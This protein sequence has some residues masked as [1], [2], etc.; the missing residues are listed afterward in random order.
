MVRAWDADDWTIGQAAQSSQMH[1]PAHDAVPGSRSVRDRAST[2]PS[3]F[4][5]HNKPRSSNFSKLPDRVCRQMSWRVCGSVSCGLGASRAA[6]GAKPCGSGR[7]SGACVFQRTKT[8]ETAES[9]LSC[10]LG[11]NL[12][13]VTTGNKHKRKTDYAATV[14]VWIRTIQVA[15]RLIEKAGG[16][17]VNP[18][19]MVPQA[20]VEATAL[21]RVAH[22][23]T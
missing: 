18:L 7:K 3:G 21:C 8:A 10:T 16:S 15:C 1:N 2:I 19:I 14:A 6:A 22:C 9:A 4:G 11:S 20:W 5:T 23:Q 17:F 13:A 12:V